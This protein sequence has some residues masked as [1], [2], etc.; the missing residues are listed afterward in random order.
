VRSLLAALLVAAAVTAGGA[1]QALEPPLR[2][3]RELT[4]AQLTRE[5]GR[6]RA[7][8]AQPGVLDE[9]TQSWSGRMHEVMKQLLERLSARGVRRARVVAVMGKPD[10]VLRPGDE[11]WGLIAERDRGAAQVV[12]AYRWRG[13]HDFAWFGLARGAVVSSGWWLAG[14]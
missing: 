13:W 2:P 14:E 7:K 11:R 10:G 6:L 8:K 9:E 4:I 3:V 5:L 12:L 1:A